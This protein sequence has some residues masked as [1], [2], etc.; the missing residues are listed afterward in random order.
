MKGAITGHS[1]VV[2]DLPVTTPLKIVAQKYKYAF[3]I[4]EK[5]SFWLNQA[6]ASFSLE[7]AL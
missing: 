6:V 1:P 2:D 4:T 7:R 3:Q 5:N